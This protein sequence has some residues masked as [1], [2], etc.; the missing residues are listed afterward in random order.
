MFFDVPDQQIGIAG[1][2]NLDWCLLGLR[3]SCMV[4]AKILDSD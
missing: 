1:S 4:E 3:K 2:S